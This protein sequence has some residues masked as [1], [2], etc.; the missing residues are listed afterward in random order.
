LH[1]AQERYE[2]TAKGKG[3]EEKKDVKKEAPQKDAGKEK[4][5]KAVVKKPKTSK[6]LVKGVRSHFRLSCSE[7]LL[8]TRH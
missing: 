8:I 1:D 5:T 4:D 6:G 7:P 2:A 3:S